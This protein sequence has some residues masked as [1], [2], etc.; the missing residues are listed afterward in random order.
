MR[1]RRIDPPRL[2]ESVEPRG[3]FNEQ[4]ALI[5]AGILLLS[6]VIGLYVTRTVYG[7]WH[8]SSPALAADHSQARS[9]MDVLQN[10]LSGFS[11]N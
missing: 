2:V 5:R 9:F 8:A 11:R 4:R 3:A 6:I 7:F 1:S 10:L